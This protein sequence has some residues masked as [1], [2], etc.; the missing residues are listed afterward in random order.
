MRYK[1]VALTL[2][3]AL[4]F[5]SAVMN[6]ATTS[7][8]GGLGLAILAFRTLFVSLRT[9]EQGVEVR[10]IWRTH[11]I[12]WRDIREITV[13][14][15]H[16]LLLGVGG[17]AAKKRACI[18]TQNRKIR[19]SASET[20]R[21]DRLGVAP[22]GAFLADRVCQGLQQRLAQWRAADDPGR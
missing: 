11:K 20:T 10:N 1:T 22:F 19:V 12:H 14:D 5:N 17:G 13:E 7:W 21:L 18:V 9:D 8:I 4:F 6:G 2:F 16:N 3:A 15:R